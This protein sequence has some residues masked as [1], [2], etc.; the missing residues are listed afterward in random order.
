MG[1]PLMDIHDFRADLIASA[2]S[3]ADALGMAW[4]EAF[5]LEMLERLRDAGE[6][7]EAEPCIEQ[8]VGPRNRRLMV[9]A[10]ALDEADESLHLFAAMPDGTD[11]PA[12]LTVSEARDQ[13]FARLMAVYENARSG[14][15]SANIEESRP[16]WSLAM[17]IRD[18]RPS[19]IR[20]HIL[21]DRPLSERVKSIPDGQAEDG[22][23][24]AFQ[25]W[26]LTRLKRI[27]DAMNVRDDLVVDLTLL[28]GGG[29]KALPATNG[30]GDYE[31]YLAVIPGDALAEI[32]TRHGSRLL[33]GNVRTFLGRRGNVN[34]GIQRTLEKEPSRFFAYNNGIAATASAIEFCEDELGGVHITSATDLQIV[35]GAQTTASLATALREKRLSAGSVF[36]PMKLSVVAPD[37]A[38]ELIPR[39]SQF[40]NSQNAVRASDFFANHPFHRRVEEISRRI[41]APATDGS[42][43]QTHWFYE[44]A[45][46]QYLN[47]QAGL[48]ATQRAQFA[49]MNPK[50][51][52]ITKTDLAKVETCFALEPDTAC[53]GAEKAFV[54]YAGKI[55]EL[56][57]DER[58]RTEV[59][60][61]WFRAVV[62]R[63]IIFRTVEKV[64][65]EAGWYEGGY[66]AQVVAYICAR[67]AKCTIDLSRGG[68]LDY[69][70]IW[71]M[72]GCDAVVRRQ[73]DAIGE[74]MMRVLRAPPREGQNISEWAKQQ[75]CRETALRSEVTI[76]PGLAAWV[77]DTDTARSESQQTRATG[78]VDRDLQIMQEVLAIPPERWSALR[79]HARAARLIQPYDEAALRAA[80]G[81][82]G[83][84]PNEAQPRRLLAL[85]ERS[86][87]TGWVSPE[88]RNT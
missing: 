17:S 48:T 30:E 65:S 24:V 19:A 54:V 28:P 40:A 55:T 43:V 74:V 20:L 53:R 13:G 34:R 26:D 23:L 69:R 42:Q 37:K 25:V 84:P 70:R 80:C 64:V 29:L 56:W 62:A 46:G 47:E 50:R 82:I 6:V 39:I 7:P 78:E 38:E 61:D 88:M 87:E 86:R 9:D 35:N 10:Y 58:K 11:T 44:R 59:T 81:E 41:L 1:A 45:R 12:V 75:A 21:S 63:T 36:V 73:L 3:R 31:A 76:I 15:L 5:V 52:V 51:Q 32:Y 18:T 85:V 60:D 2:T 4:R 67:L 8:L 71:G 57:K 72:Q 66:R 27:H 79:A 33:E 16:L 22:T 49:R 68:R 83:R 14:W 77:V